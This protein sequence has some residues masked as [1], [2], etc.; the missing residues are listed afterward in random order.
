MDNQH[1]QFDVYEDDDL[2]K[3]LEVVLSYD[4][5]IHWLPHL[6]KKPVLSVRNNRPSAYDIWAFMYFAKY[7]ILSRPLSQKETPSGAHIWWLKTVLDDEETDPEKTLFA[8]RK[9]VFQAFIKNWNGTAEKE[10]SNVSLLGI[11]GPESSLALAF[12]I[13]CGNGA[14]GLL[15]ISWAHQLGRQGKWRDDEY[16]KFLKNFAAAQKGT[17]ISG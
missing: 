14:K 1:P 11:G 9:Q 2:K 3:R 7:C 8:P 13:A 15:M 16:K 5:R 6:L 12:K 4:E 17:P 10:W